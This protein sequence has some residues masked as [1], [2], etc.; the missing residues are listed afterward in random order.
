MNLKFLLV[1]SAL[2]FAIGIATSHLFFPVSTLVINEPRGE[3]LFEENCAGCHNVEA[4]GSLMRGPSLYRIGEWAGS[5]I[6]GMS[7]EEYVF[8]SI[9]APDAYRAESAQGMMPGRFAEELPHQ[10]LLSITAYLIGMHKPLDYAALLKNE[11]AQISEAQVTRP[12]V[13][14]GTIERGEKL[15]QT[16]CSSCHDLEIAQNYDLYYPNLR[17]IGAHTRDYLREAI[18]EPSKTIAPGY[19]SWSLQTRD[20]ASF[21]G[22]LVY[23]DDTRVRLVV[24]QS[25]GFGVREFDKA[26]LAPFEN[27]DLLQ[28]S[29][30]SEM[31]PLGL[32]LSEQDMEDLV[33]YLTFL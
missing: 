23:E 21:F 13:A 4:D 32:A 26:S 12:A 1:A 8:Q 28:K 22:R 9:V 5:R 18:L 25:E 27:G 24:L 7:A 31:P 33:T 2:L 29:A 3:V 30:I 16:M 10:D 6:E 17:Q 11:Q 20:G 15:Y 19:D 14:M